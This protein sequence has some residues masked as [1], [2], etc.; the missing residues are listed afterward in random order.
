M[1]FSRTGYSDVRIIGFDGD[2]KSPREPKMTT[3]LRAGNA[4]G[5]GKFS[6]VPYGGSKPEHPNVRK[7]LSFRSPLV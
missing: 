7:M 4:V 6:V 1:V 3:S 5:G 2:G